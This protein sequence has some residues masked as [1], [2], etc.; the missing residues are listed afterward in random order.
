M[1]KIVVKRLRFNVYTIL[2]ALLLI[3]P[4]VDTISGALHDMVPVGQVYRFFLL[5]LMLVILAQNS[6]KKFTIVSVM[7]F[8][9]IL[10]QTVVSGVE[11]FKGVKDIIKLFTPIIMIVLMELLIIEKKIKDIYIFKIMDAWSVIYPIF[12]IGPGLF[13]YGINAYDGNVGWKGFFYAVNEISFI[14]SGL[15]MYLFWK[16][17]K[18]INIRTLVLLAINCICIALMGTKTGYAT[19]VLFAGI[20]LIDSIFEKKYTKKIRVCMLIVL[21]IFMCALGYTKIQNV[22]A[23]I[24]ER[25][26]YQKGLSHST[27][28]FLF[29][30]RLRRLKDAISIFA[31][32][33]Y[34][35]LGWGFGGEANGFPNME[36]DF[37]D[38]LFRTGLLGFCI[39]CIFY[40]RKFC[41]VSKKSLW[42]ALIIIWSIALSFGAGHVLFYGQ[43]GMMLAFN[44]IY[45]LNIGKARDKRALYTL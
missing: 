42:G 41:D 27:V 39:V 14:M 22:T 17:H 33:F 32:G 9:F 1:K 18:E 7:L 35:L 40:V 4:I 24:F 13:G 21:A 19:I 23:S 45:T 31:N 25:W 15:V 43:S 20:F 28:D 11:A 10:L 12:I 29:S 26:Q 37:L 36:M 3:M 6:Q 5:I 34:L 30:M 2:L 38:L 16:L 44:Y 8:L